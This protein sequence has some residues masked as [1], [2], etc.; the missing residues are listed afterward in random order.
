[1]IRTL[2]T[3]ALAVGFATSASAEDKKDE[4]KDKPDATK[5]EGTWTATSWERGP[6]RCSPGCRPTHGT[7]SVAGT[8]R[9]GGASTTGRCRVRIPRNRTSTRGGC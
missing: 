7:G 5:L 4:K 2:F 8:G 9:R 6:G 1:M 3:L